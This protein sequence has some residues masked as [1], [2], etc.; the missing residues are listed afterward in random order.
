MASPDLLPCPFCG[1]KATIERIGDRLQS[2]IY[3]CDCCGCTLETGEECGHGTGWNT[4]SDRAGLLAGLREAAE[5]CDARAKAIWDK[6]EE[7][8]ARLIPIREPAAS[9]ELRI[10]ACEFRARIAALE[11]EDGKK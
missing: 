5:K 1:G 7:D 4:R 8:G 11:T 9:V 6:A 3:S 10:V 2:T